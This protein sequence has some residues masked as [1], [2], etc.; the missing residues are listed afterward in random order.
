MN[1]ELKGFGRKRSW[2][3][4]DIIPTFAWTEENHE[5]CSVRINGVSADFRT[6]PILNAP[7]ERYRYTNPLGVSVPVVT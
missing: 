6:E 5:N 2:S 1:V 7:L 4:G 3:T